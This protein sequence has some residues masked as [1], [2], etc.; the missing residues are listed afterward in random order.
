EKRP[1]V[2][3]PAALRKQFIKAF[4]NLARHRD[5]HDV[6][7]DFLELAVCAIR[8][9]TVP[10]GPATDAIEE[11]Y[12]AVV[13]RDKLEDVRPVPAL[14]ALTTLAVQDGGCDFLGQVTGDLGM[15]TGHMGQFFTPYDVSRMIAELTLDTV[16]EVIAD[17][18]FV[19]VQE[20]ACGAGGMII[21]AAD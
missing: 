21:A 20:P 6:L 5:K 11:R 4:E 13:R 19:T 17:Q 14:L 9:R 2:P 18:G 1:C 15:V 10:P 16:D 3:S 7:T 12:M 8:K